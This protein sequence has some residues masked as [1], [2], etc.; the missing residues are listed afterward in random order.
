MGQ[1]QKCCSDAIRIVGPESA[2]FRGA[3]QMIHNRDSSK[4]SERGADEEMTAVLNS[5]AATSVLVH[6]CNANGPEVATDGHR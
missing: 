4:L 6:I 3:N 5:Q 2:T 1:Y